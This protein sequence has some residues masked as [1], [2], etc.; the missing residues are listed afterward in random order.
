MCVAEMIQNNFCIRTYLKLSEI[1]NVEPVNSGGST[2]NN[3]FLS[4]WHPGEL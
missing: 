3:V 1:S 2:L 4:N